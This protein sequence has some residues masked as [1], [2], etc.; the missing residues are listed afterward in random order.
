[1]EPSRRPALPAWLALTALTL[2]AF[3][4]R[5]SR[6]AESAEPMGTDGYYY[7]VQVEH[8]LREGQPH[9]P[10]ASWVLRFLAGCAAALGAPVAGVK[11][12][13]ALLAAAVVPAAFALGRALSRPEAA[14]PGGAGDG[15]AWGLALWAAA[16]PSLTL[17][18]GEFPKTLGIAA[19]LLLA[20]ALALRRPLGAA[21]AAALLAA[22]LLAATAHRLGAALAAAGVAGAALGWGL[23]R[24]RAAPGGAPTAARLAVAAVL[25]AGLFAAASA[26]LP[27][28]LHPQDVDRLTGQLAL[29][30]GAAPFAWLRLRGASLPERV[31]LALAWPAG[32]A[33]A[34][35]FLRRPERRP[36]L[37]ALLLPLAAALLPPWRRDVLDL[38]FRLA[39]VSPLAAAPLAA[40]ALPPAPLRRWPR[41]AV[42]LGLAAAL[43]GPLVAREGLD[44]A[45]GPPY[46][47]FRALLAR[48]PEQPDLLIAHQ[49]LSFLYGHLTWREAMA[50]APERALDRTRIGRIAWGI[51]AGE[52]AAYGA[53]L[54]GAPRPVLLGPGYVYVREDVWEALVAGARAAGDEDVLARIAD[55]RN[56]T[57]VRPAS[58]LRNR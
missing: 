15:V 53:L 6:L 24:A 58:M 38:G 40:L 57:A 17:L 49:G 47:R 7:V 1:V 2:L 37:G 23:R 45:A 28:L 29:G 54:P 33:G 43:A 44:P 9:V 19:P 51:R 13:A 18:A 8:L 3:A 41:A 50:W 34:W 55:W 31:E 39:L 22:G 5:W 20:L 14:E 32:L 36:V 26:T 16:S 56:P 21:G 35:A 4:A 11:L 10:D 12:G 27:G 42:A 52:W 46:A 30:P 25:A 48:L